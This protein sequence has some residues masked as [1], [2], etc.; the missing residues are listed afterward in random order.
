MIIDIDTLC[1]APKDF[2]KTYLGVIFKSNY[3]PTMGM[4]LVEVGL[5][6][7]NTSFSIRAPLGMHFG[8]IRF[9]WFL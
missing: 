2:P 4:D 3:H 6:G 7:Q 1:D 9:S 5:K 8:V